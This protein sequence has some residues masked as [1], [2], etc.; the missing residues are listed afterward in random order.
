[1]NLFNK[2]M[3]AK[4]MIS[5]QKETVSKK[6][7]ERI[8]ENTQPSTQAYLKYTSQFENGVM[9]I[10]EDEY[11][12][13][14]KLG[15]INYE[16]ATEEDQLMTVMSYAEALNTL[17]KNGRYQLFIHNKPLEDNFFEDTFL[18]YRGD[19]LDTYREEINQIIQ[20]K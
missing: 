5:K 2:K 15:E 19:S 18:D 20:K 14:V 7:K 16:V 9:H 4:P 1:M 10:V 6:K 12:R 8:L 17:D 13:M 3:L 11:S